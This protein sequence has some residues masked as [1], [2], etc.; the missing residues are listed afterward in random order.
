MRKLREY[1]SRSFLKCS[2]KD[3]SQNNSLNSQ[4]IFLAETLAFSRASLLAPKQCISRDSVTRFSR[5]LEEISVLEVVAA[6]LLLIAFLICWSVVFQTATSL[7]WSSPSTLSS[8]FST[9]H[10][11]ATR[12]THTWTTSPSRSSTWCRVVCTPSSRATL[13]TWASSPMFSIQS[14]CTF[15]VKT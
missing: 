13:R 7:S 12:C 6:I 3:L 1:F 9:W 11:L 8:T 2:Q 14:S 10:G 5:T 4:R 15:S